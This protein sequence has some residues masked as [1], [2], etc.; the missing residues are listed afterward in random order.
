MIVV[1]RRASSLYL[2]RITSLNAR[3]SPANA[4]PLPSA[5]ESCT[6]DRGGEILQSTTA[7][8]Y[9]GDNFIQGVRALTNHPSARQRTVIADSGTAH[10]D[11][12]DDVARLF[13]HH[14]WAEL[15]WIGPTGAGPSGTM[16]F[17]LHANLTAQ[18]WSI[19][20]PTS[21]TA[22]GKPCLF[23]VRFY[24]EGKKVL[25]ARFDAA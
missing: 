16:N 12:N 18:G 9:S 13:G 10:L 22:P 14:H 15:F 19:G 3:T 24:K 25:I 6:I 21:V 20:G 23:R 4:L 7:R 17:A 5:L 8:A 1:S 2:E 11:F